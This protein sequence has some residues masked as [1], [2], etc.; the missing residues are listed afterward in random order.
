MTI[1]AGAQLVTSGLQA[2]WDFGNIKSLLGGP[3]TNSQY[4]SGSEVTPWTVN[5]IN[6]DVTASMGLN[7]PVP[8]SKTWMFQKTGSSSQ[9]NG[10]EGSYGPW[11]GSSGDYWTTSYWY[12][13]VAAAGV[14]GFGVGGFWLPDWSRPYSTTIIDDRSSIIA[15]GQWRYNYTVT[16]LNENYSNAIIVDGPSWGY[17][18]SAGTLYINGLQWNKNS[19]ATNWIPGSYSVSQALK[20][21]TNNLTTST[22]N[23]SYPQGGGN[24]STYTYPYLTSYAGTTTVSTNSSAILNTDTHSVF[25]FI[26][27]NSTGTYPNGYSG[28][29]DMIFQYAAGGS[30]RT[31]GVWRFPSQRFIHWR[32]D[33]GNTGCDFGK[34]SSNQDFDINTWY[35][36]GVT[37][38]GST[39]TMYVNGESVG[40]ASVANPKTSGNAP[41]TL[42]PYYPQD[43]STMGPCQVYNRVLTSDEVFTNFNAMRGRFGI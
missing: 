22:F 2:F 38:N 1:N 28:N 17:S 23:L 33:P 41:V 11:T 30:D 9:W 15:D 39:A 24:S 27:F 43:L 31:P 32:Y 6:T 36:V 37:K 26:R 25:F 19:Y 18:S 10:W 4:N 8:N 7:V 5:G 20:D 21:L 34:N 40:T 3:T 16:R 42:Y 29:W 13:T 12:R 35:Y 14:T